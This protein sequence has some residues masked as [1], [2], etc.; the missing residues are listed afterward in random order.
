MTNT[1]RSPPD[2]LWSRMAIH[3]S[4]VVI[5]AVYYRRTG[6][7]MAAMCALVVASAAAVVVG[8]ILERT[9]APLPVILGLIP[10]VARTFLAAL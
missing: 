7:M 6:N 9:I 2:P 4:S 1:I 8:L 3:F 5:F 10:T